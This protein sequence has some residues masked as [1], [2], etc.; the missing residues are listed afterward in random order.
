[1]GWVGACVHARGAPA[2]QFF[3]SAPQIRSSF[4]RRLWNIRTHICTLRAQ[5]STRETR[6][7]RKA[8][9]APQPIDPGSGSFNPIIKSIHSLCLSCSHNRGPI[10]PY[11]HTPAPKINR[12]TSAHTP[13]HTHHQPPVLTSS[14]PLQPPQRLLQPLNRQ[15]RFLVLDGRNGKVAQLLRV[16][17]RRLLRPPHCRCGLRSGGGFGGGGGGGGRRGLIGRGRG[18]GRGRGLGRGVRRGVG[19][20]GRLVLLVVCGGGWVRV[21][22]IGY[23]DPAQNTQGHIQQ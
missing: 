15:R 16:V 18:R 14:Q 5:L 2:R 6:G 19:R 20:R 23:D 12:R 13:L 10:L 17:Q 4:E 8:K 22:L 3:F 1:M 9:R 21:G 7:Q 11:T